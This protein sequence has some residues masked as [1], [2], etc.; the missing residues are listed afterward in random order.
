[1]NE[2]NA[3]SFPW[4]VYPKEHS[5]IYPIVNNMISALTCISHF[6]SIVSLDTPC[7]I[8]VYKCRLQLAFVEFYI[9]TL[10]SS[11]ALGM[12][13]MLMVSAFRI[14]SIDL[15]FC[16]IFYILLFYL[17]SIYFCLFFY[18]SLYHFVTLPSIS[19]YLQCLFTLLHS[20]RTLFA[21]CLVITIG[22]ALATTVYLS[23]F[24]N[25]IDHF[26]ISGCS[27]NLT[28]M[29]TIIPLMF[30]LVS[31]TTIL[32]YSIILCRF[33]FYMMTRRNSTLTKSNTAKRLFV[34]RFLF[35]SSFSFLIAASLSILLTAHY[36]KINMPFLLTKLLEGLLNF[37][38][39]SHPL[40]L[41][42][43]HTNL[44]CKFKENFC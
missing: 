37:L 35:F 23:L 6:I 17:L 21:Y 11:A 15:F 5:N 2:S 9:L 41:V 40:F 16:S 4:F 18:Y 19:P 25:G 1:M 26:V 7:L 24:Y 20:V 3:T 42:Y 27:T 8:T 32:V 14:N 13:V 34:I 22:F 43:T 36:F 33:K 38:L 30:I 12:K 28:R 31:L 29:K 44:K 10:S 39:F